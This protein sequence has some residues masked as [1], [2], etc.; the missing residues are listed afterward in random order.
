MHIVDITL[1]MQSHC[2][3]PSKYDLFICN[4][5]VVAFAAKPTIWDMD[6]ANH[7]VLSTNQMPRNG[8]EEMIQ[9]TREGKL[10]QYPINNEAGECC[11]L[12]FQ[13]R[14]IKFIFVKSC[15]HSVFLL[16]VRPGGGSQCAFP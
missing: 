14:K 7:L 13:R 16:S 4:N 2:C 1:T 3:G 9:W 5:I 11:T 12:N 10:W 6:F 15:A 8:F